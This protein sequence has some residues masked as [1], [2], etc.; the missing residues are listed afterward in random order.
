MSSDED[1]NPYELLGLGIEATDADI[2]KAYRTRSLKVHPDRNRNDPKAPQKFHALNQAYE[3]LLDPLRRLA[4]D[5]KLRIQNA[6]KARYAN[7]DSKRKAM[8][9]DLEDR[10][11]AFKKQKE[12]RDKEQRDK[13]AQAEMAKGEGKRMMEE[14][15]AA[16]KAMEEQQTADAA[17]EEEEA[18]PPTIGPLDT[19]IRLKY[20]L[21][22][23]P[24]LTTA[25]SLTRLLSQFG[26]TDEALSI[27][28]IK[29]AKSSKSKD[30]ATAV[31]PFH[32]IGDAFAAVCASG[33]A[34]RG[35]D[36]IE[37]TWAGEKGK[38]PEILGW[39][40][41]RGELG[42]VEQPGTKPSAP[43]P[44]QSTGSSTAE[45]P[46]TKTRDPGMS[47]YSSFPSSF[48]TSTTPILPKSASVPAGTAGLD[49]ESLTLMRLRQAERE[50]LE[51][52][53]L[54]S[55]ATS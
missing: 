15:L 51:R 11:R 1:V 40:R 9:E 5:A 53:I 10:E 3:L 45:T 12:N 52:E 44:Q 27:L 17:K 46:Q 29:P 33:R 13:H 19:T 48:P 32:K 23:H 7:Y 21:A 2:R 36:G 8:M 24:E 35:L 54:E 39:L 20:T 49:Y 47:T 14:R 38:E 18:L 43:P 55:E 37:I 6:R 22:S 16:M 28:S 50:R 42:T 4:V 25:S 26:N 34:E 31:V 41:K 30:R